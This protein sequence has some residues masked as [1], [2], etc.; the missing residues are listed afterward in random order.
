MASRTDNHPVAF[1]IIDARIAKSKAG[2]SA[3]QKTRANRNRIGFAWLG[4]I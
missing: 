1:W 2:A 4:S 3:T